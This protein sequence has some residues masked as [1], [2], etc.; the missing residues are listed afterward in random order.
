MPI[1]CKTSSRRNTITR[2][3]RCTEYT[4]TTYTRTHEI[5]LALRRIR[6]RSL[7]ARGGAQMF[8][9][10]QKVRLKYLRTPIKTIKC[11][12]NIKVNG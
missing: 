9:G 3:I 2:A 11:D 4:H 6:M 5:R 1:L 7:D 8:C 12:K 10:Y